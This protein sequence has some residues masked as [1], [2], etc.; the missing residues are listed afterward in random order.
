M[1]VPQIDTVELEPAVCAFLDAPRFGVLATM[2]TDG[3]AQLTVIWYERDG[4]EILMN[5]RQGA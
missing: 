3:S 1:K 4:S 2:N 5:R